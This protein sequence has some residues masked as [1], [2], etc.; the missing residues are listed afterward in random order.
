M[1]LKL[2]RARKGDE[3]GLYRVK[4]NLPLPAAPV[5][6][7][8][9]GGFLLGS[10][11]ESYRFFIESALVNVLED[12]REIV[13][14]AIVLPDKLLRSS[15]L[16]RRKESIEWEN[17]SVSDL[18]EKP[19]CYF[20]QLAVLPGEKYR[21]YGSALTAITAR[22][23]FEAHHAIFATTVIEPICNRASVAFIENVGGRRVGS[24]DEFY[25]EIGALKSAVY[26]LEREVFARTYA[27]HALRSKINRQIECLGEF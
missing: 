3:T 26:L 6:T 17:F 20:E 24:V 11:V 8:A 10:S 1:S 13:G 21:F 5:E 18:L 27:A 23:A 7:Q 4:K 25:A 9:R 22:Q 15:E 2:R 14:F 16:W 12:H 19:L